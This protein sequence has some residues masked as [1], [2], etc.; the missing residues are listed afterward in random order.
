MIKTN[1]GKRLMSV[2]IVLS[3][4]VSII[5]PLSIF[6]ADEKTTLI[7]HY[8]RYNEDYQVGTSGFGLL[9]RLGQKGKLMSLLLKMTLV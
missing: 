8:Y 7:I 3:F 5:L 9:S 1:L 6:A 2:L 4:L